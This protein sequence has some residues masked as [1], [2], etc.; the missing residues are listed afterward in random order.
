MCLLFLENANI[1]AV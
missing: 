1:F